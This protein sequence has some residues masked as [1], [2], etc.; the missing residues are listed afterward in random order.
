MGSDVPRRL[1]RFYRKGEQNQ[2]QTPEQNYYSNQQ[3]NDN[4]ADNYEPGFNQNYGQAESFDKNN[5]KEKSDLERIPTM[6]YEDLSIDERNKKDIQRFEKEDSEKRLALEEIEKFKKQNNRMPNK[7][8]TEQ[9]AENLFTQIKNN[10]INY[11]GA[12]NVGQ[13]YSTRRGRNRNE[14]NNDSGLSMEQKMNQTDKL[15]IAQGTPKSRQRNLNQ[16]IVP[17]E[18]ATNELEEMGKENIKDLFDD[19]PKTK[20]ETKDEFDLGLDSELSN[21]DIT[22]NDLEEIEEKDTIEDIVGNKDSEMC[23][24]CKQ[25]TQKIIYCPQCGFAYCKSCAKGIVDG[26]AIC[27]KC[28]TK[29]KF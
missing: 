4:G 20:K 8:E 25:Q 1:R 24:N 6:D 15:S 27:P 5:E 19:N 18:N 9:I 14:S 17:Q 3:V 2:E 28:G 26:Q 7:K 29:T 16:N 10:P 12:Q 13:S 23:P 21:S 22:K 11:P